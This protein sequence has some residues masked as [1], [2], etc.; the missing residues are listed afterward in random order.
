[1]KSMAMSD[2]VGSEKVSAPFSG[3]ETADTEGAGHPLLCSGVGVGD[4]PRLP[5]LCLRGERVRRG[6]KTSTR[7]HTILPR[8]KPWQARKTLRPA[9]LD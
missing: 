4:V 8:F 9:C 7:A 3:G 2:E 6:V 5:P 1:V